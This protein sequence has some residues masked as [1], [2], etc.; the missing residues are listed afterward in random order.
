V[1]EFLAAPEYD[2]IGTLPCLPF[3][4]IPD[5]RQILAAMIRVGGVY[6]YTIGG[7]ASIPREPVRDEEPER[8]KIGGIIAQR[9]TLVT[10]LDPLMSLTALM[11]Y[12]SLGRSMLEYFVNM[13][14]GSALPCFR[15]RTKSDK[16]GKILVRKS[17]FD[18]WI[19]RY[20][21]HGRPNVERALRDA[22]LLES[23]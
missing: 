20:R 7:G 12:S 9:V 14:P 3:P 10:N 21:S 6:C 13:D 22:G 1:L 23:S 16:T 18:R 11:K 15:V 8:P 4:R 5:R 17:E 2:Q 19:E